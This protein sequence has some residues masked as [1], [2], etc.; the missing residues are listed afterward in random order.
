MARTA[1]RRRRRTEPEWRAILERFE[2][3]G[4]SVREYCAREGVSESSLQR[5]RR[6]VRSPA[7]RFVELAAP[8]SSNA[9]ATHEAWTIELELPS[10]VRLRVRG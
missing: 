9:A 10:G 3:S 6:Q 5:W 4:L 1:A 7:S 2:A 8:P